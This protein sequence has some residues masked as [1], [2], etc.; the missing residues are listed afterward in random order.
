[1]TGRDRERLERA[2]D[3]SAAAM[4]LVTKTLYHL[5]TGEKDEA[6]DAGKAARGQLDLIH[7]ELSI[8]MRSD[9]SEEP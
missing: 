4:S 7:T 5:A 1:M 3:A 9:T 2:I 8:L 6:V